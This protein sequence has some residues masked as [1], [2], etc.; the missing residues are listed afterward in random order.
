MNPSSVIISMSLLRCASD[1]ESALTFSFQS[2]CF[3]SAL[4]FQP[5][6]DAQ[7]AS[8]CLPLICRIRCYPALSV[9]FRRIVQ[10]SRYV[11]IY[12]YVNQDTRTYGVE[13]VNSKRWSQI[14][15]EWKVY[16]ALIY[17]FCE[18]YLLG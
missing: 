3:L 9:S 6:Y 1:L 2:W 5:S 13:Q 11:L 8:A 15:L 14:F 12:L 18:K 4:S 16:K 10:V 17:A 7:F